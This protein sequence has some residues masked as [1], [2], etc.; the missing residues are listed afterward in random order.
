MA[1]EAANR[2]SFRWQA[3]FCA[4]SGMTIITRVCLG[5]VARDR[6][7]HYYRARACSIGRAIPSEDALPLRLQGPNPCAGIAPGARL[8]WRRSMP[9]R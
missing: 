2:E 7:L 5:L 3:D 8:N 6:S 1:D 4:K 9:V